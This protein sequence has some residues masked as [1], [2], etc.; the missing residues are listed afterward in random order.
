MLTVCLELREISVEIISIHLESIEFFSKSVFDVGRHEP[1]LEYLDERCPA[2][3]Y[4]LEMPVCRHAHCVSGET[5][6]HGVRDFRGLS[7]LND[8]V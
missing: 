6:C 5:Y 7:D 4:L 2:R 1:V 8:F 3:R